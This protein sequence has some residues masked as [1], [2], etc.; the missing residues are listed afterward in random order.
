[1]DGGYF[2]V[3]VTHQRCV[4]QSYLQGF[5]D[6]VDVDDDPDDYIP[7]HIQVTGTFNSNAPLLSSV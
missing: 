5:E 6:L 1:M 2:S 4:I 7:E 3:S